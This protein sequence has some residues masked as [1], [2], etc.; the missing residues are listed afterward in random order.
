MCLCKQTHEI[1]RTSSRYKELS[2]PVSN[3]ETSVKR[4]ADYCT[5]AIGCDV[6]QVTLRCE[7]TQHKYLS[8]PN[9]WMITV[10]RLLDC[11]VS[12]S[13]RD[14]G[15]GR[16]LEQEQ[17]PA[18]LRVNPKNQK[19]INY[20]SV[21]YFTTMSVSRTHSTEWQADWRKWFA[22]NGPQT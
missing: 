14:V 22:W 15:R 16:K 8:P 10:W 1:H 5:V 2:S 11:K 21:D 3:L 19:H 6:S 4:N 18:H 13:A 9:A 20:F 17:A 12:S 7:F